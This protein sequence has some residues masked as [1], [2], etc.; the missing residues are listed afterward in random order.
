MYKFTNEWKHTGTDASGHNKMMTSSARVLAAA[1]VRKTDNPTFSGTV[2]PA[3]YSYRGIQYHAIGSGDPAWDDTDVTN[4][5]D[6][7]SSG[8]VIEVQR[9]IPYYCKFVEDYISVAESGSSTVLIDQRLSQFT[10]EDLNG[11]TVY[12]GSGTNAGSGSFVDY[13]LEP[14]ILSNNLPLDK[15]YVSPAFASGFDSTSVYRISDVPV[16]GTR[17]TNKIHLKTHFTRSA[18]GTVTIREHGLFGAN[19]TSSLNSG[20]LFNHVVL[21]STNSFIHTSG[22]TET[23]EFFMKLG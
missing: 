9:E 20:I 10:P 14:S 23:L 19:A 21:G 2:D 6:I 16:S 8:L 12:V 4:G 18:S 7:A 3:N 11:R 13:S 15:I 17:I 22:T 1:L 5:I